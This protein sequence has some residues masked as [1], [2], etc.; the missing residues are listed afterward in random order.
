[1]VKYRGPSSWGCP[2]AWFDVDMI[3]GPA[4]RSTWPASGVTCPVALTPGSSPRP[5]LRLAKYDCVVF[6]VM[7]NRGLPTK[8]L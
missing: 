3:R 8:K 7:P 1:M 6:D 5:S 2:E 4:S